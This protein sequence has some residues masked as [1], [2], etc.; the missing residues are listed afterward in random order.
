MGIIPES[1]LLLLWKLSIQLLEDYKS[2]GSFDS[3]VKSNCIKNLIDYTSKHGINEINHLVTAFLDALCRSEHIAPILADIV[4]QT[5]GIMA[6]ELIGEIG[7][8]CRE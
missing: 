2:D 7:Q 8:I 6:T 1:F 3:N 4:K 5:N